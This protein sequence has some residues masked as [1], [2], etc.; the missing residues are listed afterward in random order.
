MTIILTCIIA[1]LDLCSILNVMIVC[2]SNI[3]NYL[4]QK[5]A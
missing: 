4:G 2:Q 5:L 3:V 1:D